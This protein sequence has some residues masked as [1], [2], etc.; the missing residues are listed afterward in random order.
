[1][2][3]LRYF[4]AHEWI[5]LLIKILQTKTIQFKNKEHTKLKNEM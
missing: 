2:E 4:I 5:I 3:Y 1:M